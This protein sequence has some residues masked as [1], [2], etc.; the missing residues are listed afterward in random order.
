VI[1]GMRSSL[2]LLI[3]RFCSMEAPPAKFSLANHLSRCARKR[4]ANE[5]TETHSRASQQHLPIEPRRI[6]NK[7]RIDGISVDL[8][9]AS[10]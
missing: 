2:A 7:D 8:H 5:E 1:A 6:V 4:G 9:V 3:E 10:G